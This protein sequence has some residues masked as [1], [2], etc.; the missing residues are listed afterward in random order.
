MALRKLRRNGHQNMLGFEANVWGR[1]Q[2]LGKGNWKTFAWQRL[3]RW[4]LDAI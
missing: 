2:V 4:A 3:A 1:V